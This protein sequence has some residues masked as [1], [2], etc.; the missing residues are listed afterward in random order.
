MNSVAQ[1][2]WLGGSESFRTRG[3]N[4]GSISWFDA[5]VFAKFYNKVENITY[6]EKLGV[7]MLEPYTKQ[8]SA[9]N[10]AKSIPI[11]P[12]DEIAKSA[13]SDFRN[14][15]TIPAGW[16]LGYNLYGA[17]ENDGV[18]KN[19]PQ[20]YSVKTLVSNTGKCYDAT[21]REEAPL[22]AWADSY[23]L[24]LTREIITVPDGCCGFTPPRFS[25]VPHMWED[26]KLCFFHQG[27][28]IIDLT[29]S[30]DPT[31]PMKVKIDYVKKWFV[32]SFDDENGEEKSHPEWESSGVGATNYLKADG[33]VMLLIRR[34]SAI[35]SV[36]LD[37]IGDNITEFRL[38]WKDAE[39]QVD[40][41]IKFMFTLNY[42][43][44]IE[45]SAT[46]DSS[47]NGT[48]AYVT[49]YNKYKDDYSKMMLV[50]FINSP[51]SG[52]LFGM[53][54]NFIDGRMVLLNI[55][56]ELLA[57]VT[58]PQFMTVEREDQQRKK[59]AGVTGDKTKMYFSSYGACA[60]A[61]R[62]LLYFRNGSVKS[63]N[64]KLGEKPDSFLTDFTAIISN[65]LSMQSVQ[66]TTDTGPD[67]TKPGMGTKPASESKSEKEESWY[68]YTI[69]LTGSNAMEDINYF[70]NK[71]ITEELSADTPYLFNAKITTPAVPL[72]A[73]KDVLPIAGVNNIDLIGAEFRKSID[74]GNEYSS[75]ALEVVFH[76]YGGVKID[77]FLN[78]PF[79]FK[80]GGINSLIHDY[81]ADHKGNHAGGSQ[82][83]NTNITDMGIFLVDR[84]TYTRSGSDFSD[85]KLVLSCR[86]IVKKF[87]NAIVVNKMMLDGLSHTDAMQDLASYAHMGQRLE[88]PADSLAK[89][90]D[91]PVLP[92]SPYGG[93]PQWVL[94]VGD[95]IWD[96]MVKIRQF[97]GWALYV[98]KNGKLIYRHY[99][100]TKLNKEALQALVKYVFTDRYNWTDTGLIGSGSWNPPV[101]VLPM[102]ELSEIEYDNY[103]T[104]VVVSGVNM[105]HNKKIIDAQSGPQLAKVGDRVSYMYWDKKLEEKLG[106]TRVAALEN[107]IL[108]NVSSLK[109]I[110]RSIS[111]IVF[112]TKKMIAFKVECGELM[113]DVDL[114]DPIAVLDSEKQSM[115]LYEVTSLSYSIRKHSI[116]VE[117]EARSYPI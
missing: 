65:D 94:S 13:V 8:L 63:Q 39:K 5:D 117:V 34:P 31:V 25:V 10:M 100:R 35:S 89:A 59:Y 46:I 51:L 24:P 58:I 110:A 103:R 113:L 91:D 98:D 72:T 111:K 112:R 1:L 109:R 38:Y 23:Y 101:T 57:S 17:S 33:G 3:L 81:S 40:F 61:I 92:I 15:Y 85:K 76:K 108:S 48:P 26:K 60:F 87:E 79:I 106:E 82:Y 11:D 36:M 84:K 74:D 43:L 12:D 30:T 7:V 42:K 83:V 18:A 77:Q 50:S 71:S 99:D 116:D 45:F 20:E 80:L 9:Y 22:A 115:E 62:P 104:R 96:W 21:V 66:I 49:L 70:E 2:A 37:Q 67:Y 53:S 102:S 19:Q 16:F 107:K 64:Y 86:D 47:L 105:E 27:N 4:I 88:I 114:Y 90:V 73:D 55:K 6:L 29:R 69:L 14:R 32:R 41:M 68:N 56:N 93:K 78:A 75:A 54:I 44:K 97:S 52:D 95:N 28:N